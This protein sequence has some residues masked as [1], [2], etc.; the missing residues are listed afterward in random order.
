[1]G[2]DR[3]QGYFLGRPVPAA[4]LPGVVAAVPE[5]PSADGIDASRPVGAALPA[6][7]PEPGLPRAESL[8]PR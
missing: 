3:L 4:E 7:R 1:M 8:E 2:C 5:L 6:P